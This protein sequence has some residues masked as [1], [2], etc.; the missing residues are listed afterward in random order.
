VKTLL[1]L[2]AFLTVCAM[3][4]AG[5]G[6]AFTHWRPI[7]SRGGAFAV[8]LIAVWVVSVLLGVMGVYAGS[9]RWMAWTFGGILLLGSSVLLLDIGLVFI[10]PIALFVLT[11][12]MVM[13]RQNPS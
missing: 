7:P 4:A 8:L 9:G 12:S 1:V 11:Y 10:A 5:Y 3:L 2:V 13:W 6:I